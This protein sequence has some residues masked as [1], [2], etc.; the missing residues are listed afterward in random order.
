VGA[1][2]DKTPSAARDVL[3]EAYEALVSLGHSATDAR[4]KIEK[5]TAEGKT[6]KSVE[7]FLTEIYRLE[8]R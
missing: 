8:R 3:H 6:F 5:A 2:F 7:E 1:D 4:K